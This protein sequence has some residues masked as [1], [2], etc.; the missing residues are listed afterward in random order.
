MFAGIKVYATSQ[1]QTYDCLAL[2]DCVVDEP[3]LLYKGKEENPLGVSPYTLGDGDRFST[4]HLTIEFKNNLD[5]LLEE[6]EGET[7]KTFGKIDVCVCWS[8]VDDTFKGY[9]IEQIT[10]SNLDERKYPGVT[11]LLRHNGDPHIISVIML[12]TATDM[13]RAGRLKLPV[14]DP[15]KSS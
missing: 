6:I 4:R 3:G 12:E 11:H 8:K 5:G 15:K 10:E 2:Y 7:P 14:S 13:I 1:S 9:E